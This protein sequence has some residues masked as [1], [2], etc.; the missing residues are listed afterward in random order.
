MLSLYLIRHA[1]SSWADPGMNDFDR[2]LNDRGKKNAPF[3]GK[4]LKKRGE[5]ADLMV[6]STANRAIST[7]RLIAHELDYSLNKIKQNDA[8]YHASVAT[9]LK[10]V[11]GLPDEKKTVMVFGH[12]DG[13]TAFANYLTDE[14][15]G[16]IPT[17]G[18][19]KIDFDFDTWKMVSK[20]TGTMDY[21]D[22]PKRYKENQ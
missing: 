1:K 21:F 19:V 14:G 18:I 2:P 6:S 11:N 5:H 3:M 17:C 9:W 12:N 7:A 15:I 8:L 13:I 4:Q 10:E 16:N 20:G 22:Y